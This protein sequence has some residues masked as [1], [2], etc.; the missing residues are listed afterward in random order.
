M[1]MPSEGIYSHEQHL[2]IFN[3]LEGADINNTYIYGKMDVPI[4]MEQLEDS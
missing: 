4:I 1:D 2:D 3:V